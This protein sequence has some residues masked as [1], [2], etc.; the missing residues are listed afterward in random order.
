MSAQVRV[1][2]EKYIKEEDFE[3]LSSL[4][5]EL[6]EKT[7]QEDGCIEYTFNQDKDDI[8]HFTFIETWENMDALTG[9]TKAEHYLEI[10]PKL[11]ALCFKDGA[12]SIYHEFA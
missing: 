11:N 2:S 10:I 9:H 5:G 7:R 3:T 12:L 6:I 4:L 8:T 1:V